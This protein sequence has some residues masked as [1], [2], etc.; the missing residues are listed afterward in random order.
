MLHIKFCENQSTGSGDFL[1]FFYPIWAWQ[2]SWLCDQDAQ[3]KFFCPS[4]GGSTQNLALVVKAVSEMFE[5]VNEWTNR[6]QNMGTL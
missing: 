6:L 1:S 4:H 5:I 3:T 2:P